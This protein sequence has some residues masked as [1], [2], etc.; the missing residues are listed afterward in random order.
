MAQALHLQQT[1]GRPSKVVALQLEPPQLGQSIEA[2]RQ[3]A[4]RV[5]VRNEGVKRAKLADARGQRGQP[6]VV[7]VENLQSSQRYD[8]VWKRLQLGIADEAKE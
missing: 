3:L 6:V 7:D 1:D 8:I 5:V 2:R 4:K